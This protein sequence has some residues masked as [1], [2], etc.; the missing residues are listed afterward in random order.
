M[1]T[2]YFNQRSRGRRRPYTR[3]ALLGKESYEFRCIHSN[4]ETARLHGL[5]RGT[6]MYSH[7]AV[8]EAFCDK[9]LSCLDWQRKVTHAFLCVHSNQ[10]TV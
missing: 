8:V 1:L 4:R 3:S 5:R 2:L 7:I 6:Y 10:E 9:R